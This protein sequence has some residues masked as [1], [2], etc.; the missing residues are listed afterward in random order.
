MIPSFTL[1]VTDLSFGYASHG[2]QILKSITHSFESGSVNVIVGPSGAGKSTLL[3][4][5]AGLLTPSS[6]D[7]SIT[8]SE[9][10]QEAFREEESW[11][12]FVPQGEALLPWRTVQ[13]NIELPFELGVKRHERSSPLGSDKVNQALEKFKLSEYRDH[14]PD[15]LS[16]GLKKLTALAR[17]WIENR[18]VVLLDEPFSSIDVFSRSSLYGTIRSMAKDE[19]KLVFLV[20]HDFY[21]CERLLVDSVLLMKDSSLISGV[22]IH[23]LYEERDAMQYPNSTA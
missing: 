16:S 10:I 1:S 13:G 7:I 8:F 3:R 12:S 5:I 6:G 23:R 2:R 22:D 18:P 21:D 20:T 9:E 14:Y 4:L 15:E 17:V 11:C 19:G